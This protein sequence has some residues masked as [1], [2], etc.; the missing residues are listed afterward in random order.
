MLAVLKWDEREPYEKLI[1]GGI[2]LGLA[3][4]ALWFLL[5][6]PVL[7][8]IMEAKS[9]SETALRDHRIVTRA[10][11]Q[12]GQGSVASGQPFSRAVLI[13]AARKKSVRL[14]RVQPDGESVN[15]WIDEVST[16]QLYSLINSLVTENGAEVNRATISASDSGLLSAQL[17]LK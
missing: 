4:M 11:P 16:G 9:L 6:S 8:S 12:M 5:I 3:L 17:T 14:A 7:S 10:L 13:E 15:V 2:A 1:M